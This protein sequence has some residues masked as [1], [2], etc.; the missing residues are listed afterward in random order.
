M[1]TFKNLTTADN[2]NKMCANTAI[3]HMG[4][5]FTGMTEEMITAEMPVDARTIQPAGLLHGGCHALLAETLA[6]LASFL[7][8]EGSP[9]APVGIEVTAKHVKS[10]KSGKIRGTV[11]AGHLGKRL[12]L[13]E[14]KIQNEN[15]DLLSMATVTNQIIDKI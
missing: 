3:S 2:L 11:K 1:I 5:L 13:W 4:I 15:G 7:L 12:H 6:G 10:I 9:Q 14:I 8:L